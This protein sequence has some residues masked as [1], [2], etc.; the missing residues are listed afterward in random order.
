MQVEARYEDAIKRKYP[1]H[2]AIAIAKDPQGKYNPITLGWTMITSHQPPMMAISVW[3]ASTRRLSCAAGA[4]IA[5]A[6]LRGWS[7][8]PARKDIR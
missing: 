7:L 3:S 1:E 8:V 6:G 4:A 5:K 2:I